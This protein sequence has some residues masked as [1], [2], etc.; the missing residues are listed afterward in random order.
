MSET[1][2]SKRDG[3]ENLIYALPAKSFRSVRFFM[4]LKHKTLFFMFFSAHQGCN[5]L[6]KKNTHKKKKPQ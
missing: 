5:Y 4:F 3:V 2:E 6:I 1:G